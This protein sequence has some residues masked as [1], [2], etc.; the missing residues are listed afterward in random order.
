M[1]RGFIH[2]IFFLVSFEQDIT[3]AHTLVRKDVYKAGRTLPVIAQSDTANLPT[4]PPMVITNALRMEPRSVFLAG[5]NQN[6]IVQSSSVNLQMEPTAIIY[7]I[8]K[9]IKYVYQAGQIR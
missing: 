7:V 2:F 8:Q 1:E 6:R 5:S 3:T 9:E 4:T